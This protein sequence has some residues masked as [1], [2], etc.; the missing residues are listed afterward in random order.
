[1]QPSIGP[2]PFLLFCMLWQWWCQP[3]VGPTQADQHGN[4]CQQL[5]LTLARP[6]WFDMSWLMLATTLSALAAVHLACFLKVSFLSNHNPKYF[7]AV[8]S[9]ICS[10]F[11]QK[12]GRLNQQR[13]I[14]STA[15][16]FVVAWLSLANS[17]QW[18]IASRVVF[19]FRLS[20]GISSSAI[21]TRVSSVLCII[22]LNLKIT[23]QQGI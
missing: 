6:P 14:N 3:S 21:A 10:P 16:I 5:T 19:T 11:R 12:E 7:R 15:S 1:M 20:M 23:A 13:H 8:Q 9:L 4:V 2:K 22:P 17:I 18:V